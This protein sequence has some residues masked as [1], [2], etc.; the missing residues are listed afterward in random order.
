MIPNTALLGTASCSASW[1]CPPTTHTC[2]YS[3]ARWLSVNPV[4][5]LPCFLFPHGSWLNLLGR[6]TNLET[7][8]WY[9]RTWGLQIGQ[10][11]LDQMLGKPVYFGRKERVVS[12]VLIKSLIVMLRYLHC[13]IL[14]WYF[15]L[16]LLNA[17][18]I[19]SEDTSVLL[20]NI[21]N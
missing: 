15:H 9:S 21:S 19:Y 11:W 17:S 1:C 12:S 14:C 8:T 20:I 7:L 18:Y 6:N 5:H 13:V 2:T 10:L 4:L 16:C 3:M